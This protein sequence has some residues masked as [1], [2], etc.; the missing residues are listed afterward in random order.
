VIAFLLHGFY[1]SFIAFFLS[2]I[3]G[4]LSAG[5]AVVSIL[6][7]AIFALKHAKL[8]QAQTSGL[9]LKA[10]SSGMAGMLEALIIVFTMYVCWR[11]FLY[12]FFEREGAWYTLNPNNFGDLPLHI[13]YIR[14]FA[15][16]LP[17]PPVN[18]GFGTEILRYP[19]GVDLYD[20]LWE[21][22]GVPL[23]AHLLAVGMMCALGT[24]IVLRW[25][26]GWWA[27]GAFFLSGG[28]LGWNVV[29]GSAPLYDIQGAVEWKNMLLSVFITQR[30]VMFGLPL[31]LILLEL[32]RREF[33]DETTL[34]RPVKTI[35]GFIW[36]ILPFYHAH[37]FVI[38]SLL[39]G[40]LA[41]NGRGLRGLKDLLL[42]RMALIAY[43]PATYFV[44]RTSGG[45]K[46][47][48]IVHWDW[49]WAGESKTAAT[50]MW[51]NFG[52]WLLLPVAIAVCLV[53]MKN[54]FS[55][56]QRRRLWG[57]LF[58]ALACFALFFNLMLAPWNW[59]NIKILIWPYLLIARLGW[60]V[61]EPCFRHSVGRLFRIPVAA[62]LFFSGFLM[63]AYSLRAPSEVALSLYPFV[64][65]GQ[66][67]GALASVPKNAKFLAAPTHDHALTYFG[68]V[69]I[70]GHGGHLW[71]H[72]I[73]YQDVW[74][75]HEAVMAGREDWLK[76]AKDL[77]ATHIYWGPHERARYGLERKPWA[78][79]LKDVSR[80][81][82][83]SIYEIP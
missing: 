24:L 17:F 37:F 23:R 51:T 33:S 71:S 35:L 21:I 44:L 18:P 50:F 69:R 58:I 76:L 36:G 4:G 60:V 13:S 70:I 16:G 3:F 64:D 5:V 63:I 81:P 42:S 79:T 52:V 66:A 67:E 75:R 30:G 6:V 45:F 27:M 46:K 68:R 47:A 8:L 15:E 1:A 82:E 53:V 49:W 54:R 19:F 62:V 39:M 26:G 74:D 61:V 7:G 78:D 83:V 40:A 14:A 11:H 28:W 22:L 80:V 12:L 20:A 48:N 57:E 65:L 43:L 10:F 29:T 41:I 31:G 59:D 55:Q 25:F 32:V 56:V 9:T 2:W 73:D 72:A 34:T 77:G 38:V